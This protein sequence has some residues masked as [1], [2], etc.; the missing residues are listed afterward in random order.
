MSENYQEAISGIII[1]VLVLTFNIICLK[2]IRNLK[3]QVG[4]QPL[5]ERSEHL[6]VL[7]NIANLFESIIN[8]L[9]GIAI[10]SLELNSVYI[11]IA[12]YATAT[13]AT[14]FYVSCMGLRILRVKYLHAKRLGYIRKEIGIFERRSF[15]LIVPNIYSLGIV[16]IYFFIY[17]CYSEDVASSDMIRYLYAIESIGFF[18]LSFKYYSIAPHPSI[19]VEYLFYS[20]IWFSGV[21]KNNESRSF[22]QIP[23]R[24]CIL[25]TISVLSIS[26]HA[27][28]LAPP[29]PLDI[30]F[31]SIFMIEEIYCDFEKYI[32]K[33]GDEREKEA[34]KC[35]SDL[36]IFSKEPEK[37]LVSL[38]G[39]EI[40]ISQYGINSSKGAETYE[41]FKESLK[42]S[43]NK[44]LD[45]YLV[46]NEHKKMR[47]DYFIN[48]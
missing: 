41:E 13:Y 44:I 21:L 28:M 22:Y 14:R 16:M 40:P 11:L 19:P 33:H 9:A 24:N 42:W 18:F 48:S 35:Y 32:E 45:L 43:L 34:F 8:I 10:Y 23:I 25:L 46:S 1:L 47:K 37:V 4:E 29:L 26:A 39:R 38:L 36:T 12:F 17:Y 6:V 30:T 27:N 20:I 3:Y 15:S 2:Y 5:Y 7:A 31:N